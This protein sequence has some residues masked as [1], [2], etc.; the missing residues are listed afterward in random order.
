MVKQ[1]QHLQKAMGL[2]I[3]LISAVTFASENGTPMSVPSQKILEQAFGSRHGCFILMR[4]KDEQTTEFNH[5]GCDEKLPPCSTFKIWNSLIGLENKLIDKPDTPF[6]KWDGKKRFISGWNKNLT[7]RE[8]FRVSCVPAF[9]ELARNIGKERMQDW[10]NKIEYGDRNISAGIDKFWLTSSSKQPIQI[11]P[12]QQV[13]LLRKLLAG[14]LPF[15]V[16]SRA[17]LEDIMLIRKLEHGNLYGKT[18]SGVNK[19]GDYVLGWFVGFLRYNDETYVF[20]CTLQG[21]KL[22]GNEA[23]ATVENIIEKTGWY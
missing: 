10:I 7:L 6:Y 4:C 14:K 8:A 15:S 16:K 21:P 13:E 9:Q 17:V 1:M 22:S 18:G 3:M 19:S 23:R 20:A 11:T 5:A 2:L 12:R